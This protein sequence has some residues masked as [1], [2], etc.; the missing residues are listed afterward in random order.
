MVLGV[1][2]FVAAL[3]LAS[4]AAFLCLVLRGRRLKNWRLYALVGLTYFVWLAMSI[5]YVSNE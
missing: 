4:F 2:C 1:R 5:Y 3:F